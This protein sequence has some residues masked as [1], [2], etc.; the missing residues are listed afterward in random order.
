MWDRFEAGLF[1]E[2]SA[3]AKKALK[4]YRKDRSAARA[5]L[6]EYSRDV[7]LEAIGKARK[8]TEQ[9]K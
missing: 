5:Y 4:L 3:V 8:L 2:Q 7:A 1:A 6:T 9:L